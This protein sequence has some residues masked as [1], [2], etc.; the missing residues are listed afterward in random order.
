[1]VRLLL[2]PYE[3]HSRASSIGLIGHL[4]TNFPA[5]HRLYLVL[6]DRA[7]PPTEEE[8]LFASAKKILNHAKASE[9]L[10]QLEKA[11][12]TILDAFCQKTTVRAQ[13]Y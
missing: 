7:E 2:T 4:K 5:M 9:Y 13:Y 1:M 3:S 8:V 12:N 6:K 11:S 10:L